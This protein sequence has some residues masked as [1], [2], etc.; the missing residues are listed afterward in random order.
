MLTQVRPL[1]SMTVYQDRMDGW[2]GAC[3]HV[4]MLTTSNE[5]VTCC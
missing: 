5:Q 2:L 1:M 3:I 4:F